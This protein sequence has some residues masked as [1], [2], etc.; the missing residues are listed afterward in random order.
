VVAEIRI[1]YEGNS[2]LTEG[3]R[4]FFDNLI[5]AARR[6]R[7]RVQFVHG[8]ARSVAIGGFEFAR[9]T[10]PKS[11]S[12]LLIASEGPDDGRL[13]A[14]LRPQGAQ[15]DSVFWMV[16]LMESCFPAYIPAIKRYY[17]LGI[18]RTRLRGDRAIEQI[19]KK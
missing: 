14:R 9:H 17:G 13:F 18:S 7:C 5:T 3:F 15:K 16:Q 8:G 19:A 4:E 1:H 11:W 6:R 10:H 12:I 2:R